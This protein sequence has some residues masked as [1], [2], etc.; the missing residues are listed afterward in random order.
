MILSSVL[1]TS[2]DPVD[3]SQLP[4][5]VDENIA[6]LKSNHPEM[7]FRL[8]QQDEVVALIESK[9]S[10][11]VLDAYFA[12]APFAF[13]A[14]LARYCILHEYGGLYADLS[15]YF[16]NPVPFEPGRLTV[17]RGNL[18]SSPWDTSNG[19]IFAPPK[20]FVFEKVIELLCANVARKYYGQ[21]ALCPTG[22]VLWGKALAISC[23]AEDV[24]PGF[25][26]L[27]NR[28]SVLGE[29]PNAPLPSD[30]VIHTQI[31]RRDLIAVKR[32]PLLS[33]GLNGIGIESGNSYRD[34]WFAR[35]VYL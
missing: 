20:H 28:N 21:T 15:Y 3:P 27:R 23:E 13:R 9:F 12:M 5:L 10:K 30:R 16:I 29:Y 24:Y 6:S 32:K 19:I 35:E 26:S 8:F 1:I 18:V 11:E 34:M 2:D 4:P 14:D 31:H 25:A 22:P 33:K 17:F 7:P